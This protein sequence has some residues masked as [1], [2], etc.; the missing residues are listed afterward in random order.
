MPIDKELAHMMERLRANEPSAWQSDEKLIISLDFGTTYS[1]I[2][3]CFA[4]QRN[5]QVAAVMNWPGMPM[6]VLPRAP[7]QC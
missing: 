4:N 7:T 1:G 5:S 2:G 3:F 6:P